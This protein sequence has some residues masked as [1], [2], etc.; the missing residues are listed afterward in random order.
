M[1]SCKRRRALASR[2]CTLGMSS[3]HLASLDEMKEKRLT[4]PRTPGQ[5]RALAFTDLPPWARPP[6]TPGLLRALAFTDLPPWVRT[7]KTKL[8][9]NKSQGKLVAKGLVNFSVFFL[10]RRRRRQSS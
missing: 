6:R 2:D 8:M 4:V 3:V 1:Q 7:R 10:T 9:V 5:L